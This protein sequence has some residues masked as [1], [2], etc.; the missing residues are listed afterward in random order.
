MASHCSLCALGPE[1]EPRGE[2]AFPSGVTWE[3]RCDRNPIP[4]DTVQR[5]WGP[6]HLVS[7]LDFQSQFKHLCPQLKGPSK[8]V[9][10]QPCYIKLDESGSY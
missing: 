5:E 10:L 1:W 6:E 4:S 8:L 9:A 2:G 7:P 3:I